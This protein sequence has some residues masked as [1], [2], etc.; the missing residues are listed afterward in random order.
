MKIRLSSLHS[1]HVKHGKCLLER[2]SLTLLHDYSYW[3]KLS[4]YSLEGAL[5]QF[6][7]K[8]KKAQKVVAILTV[9]ADCGKSYSYQLTTRPIMQLCSLHI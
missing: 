6:S 7:I 4:N 3:H 8:M 9:S 1:T 2:I 5:C